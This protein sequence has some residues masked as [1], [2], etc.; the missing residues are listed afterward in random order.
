MSKQHICCRSPHKTFCPYLATKITPAIPIVG[1]VLYI[2][3]M[4]S[5]LR[6]TFTDPGVIPRASHDEA[7]YIEKQIDILIYNGPFDY[8]CLLTMEN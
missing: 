1:A 7:A 5:L 8:P 2:F 6:T 4:S 3:T